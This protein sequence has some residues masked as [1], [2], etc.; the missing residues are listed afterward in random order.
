MPSPRGAL[1]Q[2]GER[3]QI[4]PRI[5]AGAIS[6]ESSRSIRQ[7]TNPLR[8]AVIGSELK[9][10]TLEV[11]SKEEAPCFQRLAGLDASYLIRILRLWPN[12]SN[13]RL[14]LTFYQADTAVLHIGTVGC[15]HLC[16]DI[17]AP[18]LTETSIAEESSAFHKDSSF[19]RTF[20][21]SVR[22]CTACSFVFYHYRATLFVRYLVQV[23]WKRCK[24][25]ERFQLG[26][27]PWGRE[28]CTG[29]RCRRQNRYSP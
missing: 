12:G 18:Q 14:A 22:G 13:S 28:F 7:V 10:F 25:V 29:I 5:T 1:R 2:L 11:R 20:S 3:H 26:N 27:V 15:K 24:V 19:L 8:R 23:V 17:R 4:R 9:C 21:R 16:P 6:L